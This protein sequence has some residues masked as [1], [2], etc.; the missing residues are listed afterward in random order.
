MQRD[1]AGKKARKQ[2]LSSAPASTHA[3]LKLQGLV[4]N[5][6]S[7]QVLAREKDPEDEFKSDSDLTYLKIN[8]AKQ[9]EVKGNTK[10]EGKKGQI[11]AGDFDFEVNA[12]TDANSGQ[13]HGKR[14]YAPVTFTKK[15]DSTT[16]RLVQALATNEQIKLLRAV[17]YASGETGPYMVI[18]FKD[19]RFTKVKSSKGRDS[20]AF[21]FGSYA[22]KSG[23]QE[24]TDDWNVHK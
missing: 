1:I 13:A 21:V 11:E 8:L 15:T 6:A 24:T 10:A 20:I 4:G 2:Q 16:P 18:E 14:Q 9:G 7:A 23:D 19:G 5:R 22:M 17:S 3:A 12:S